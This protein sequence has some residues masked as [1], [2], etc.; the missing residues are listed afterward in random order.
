M[1][2]FRIP[3]L[4]LSVLVVLIL[5]LQLRKKS[6]EA[7]DWDCTFAYAEM[8]DIHRIRLTRSPGKDVASFELVD[9]K[10]IINGKYEVR[11]V[12]FVNMTNAIARIEVQRPVADAAQVNVVKE[13]MNYSVKVELFKKGKDKPVHAFMVGSPTTTND[14]TH[15]IRL[16]NGELSDRAYVVRIPGFKGNLLPR[17]FINEEEWRKREYFAYTPEQIGNISLEYFDDP[18]ASFQLR[19]EPDAWVLAP[20]D[21]QFRMNKEIHEARINQFLDAFQSLSVEAFDQDYARK[22]TVL[23]AGPFLRMTVTDQEGESKSMDVYY[24][25]V[26]RSTKKRVEETTGEI[27][28]YDVDRYFVLVNNGADFALIQHYVFGKVFRKYADFFT[29]LDVEKDVS[30]AESPES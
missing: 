1:K 23:M 14:G 16:K 26:D 29:I 4:I 21:E 19:Q 24:K 5:V 13:F 2:Q 10:W 9:G 15:M 28:T 30:K 22:D 17:F 20:K 3:L 11:K 7:G 18:S 6:E 27:M 8:D 12:P 25:P